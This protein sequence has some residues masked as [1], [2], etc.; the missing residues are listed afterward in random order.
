MCKNYQKMVVR[1]ADNRVVDLQALNLRICKEVLCIQDWKVQRLHPLVYTAIRGCHRY[2]GFQ[3]YLV[4][5]H[6][7]DTWLRKV[8]QFCIDERLG[9]EIVNT[10]D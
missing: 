9:A 3:R 1:D 7:N 2:G 5:T 8:V 6:K 10:R 4:R